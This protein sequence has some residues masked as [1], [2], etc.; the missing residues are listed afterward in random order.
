MQRSAVWSW[1]TGGSF[2][3]YNDETA[4]V[5]EQAYQ[6]ARDSVTIR[7]D[8]GEYRIDFRKMRQVSVRDPHKFRPIRRDALEAD[9]RSTPSTSSSSHASPP[10]PPPAQAPPEASAQSS[11]WFW[12]SG[13]R[14]TSYDADTSRRIEQ[15]YQAGQRQ[16]TIRIP[17][18][19]WQA[20]YRIDFS[21]MQQV[22]LADPRKR[23]PVQ[24]AGPGGQQASGPGC[25]GWLFAGEARSSPVSAK[26][27]A[28]S[29]GLKVEYKGRVQSFHLTSC[30]AAQSIMRSQFHPSK[31]GM[32][33]P[34]IYFAGSPQDC[35]RKATA[36]ANVQDGAVLKATV[37][38][39]HSIVVTNRDPGDAVCQFLGIQQ[40]GDLTENKLH[41]AGCQS[42]FGTKGLTD[43]DEWA[44]PSNSQISGTTLQGYSKQGQE[45]PFWLWPQWV[46]VLA[47]AVPVD[48]VA[49][50]RVSSSSAFHLG[51]SPLA[52]P[53]GV[54]VNAAGR[55]IHANGRFMTYAEARSQGWGGVE[56]SQNPWNRHQQD[57]AGRGLSRQQIS[58]TYSPRQSSA[59]RSSNTAPSSARQQNAWNEHQRS[60]GGQG[61]SRAEIRAAYPGRAPRETPSSAGRAP[62]SRRASTPSGRA[63]NAWNDFQRSMGGLGLSRSQIR[64]SYTPSSPMI[65][66][67]QG[68]AP[69]TWNQ[70]QRS[71]GGQGF[72][73]DQIRAAYPGGS[74]LGGFSLGS[75]GSSGGGL[76]WNAFRSSVKGQGMSSA[77][78]SAAYHAQ[79]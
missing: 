66:P 77:E 40:W 7:L 50:E 2:R 53:D 34:F 59:R 72:S 18:G 29:A 13:G 51:A 27:L 52:P 26:T 41:K 23:R 56:P 32:L 15:A 4:R 22:S 75:G 45:L 73:R 60:M 17:V 28:R 48:D 42:V 64:S 47:S 58:R 16:V 71:M 6:Q 35:E 5:I 1:G 69:N 8:Y 57:M 14:M 68:R 78:I 43:R 55:P 20:E 70:H 24:R 39:G 54:R 31:R 19:N 36:V 10:L 25:L 33:G 61:H 3:P 63:P 12:G 11:T 9:G 30:E 76:G 65:A 67:S 38:L 44:V 46:H 62:S 21:E 74:S 37:D 79:K 49:V